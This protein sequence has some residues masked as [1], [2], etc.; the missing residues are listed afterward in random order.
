MIVARRAVCKRV[1]R[2]TIA[3]STTRW[4]PERHVDQVA[5]TTVASTIDGQVTK[6]GFE[7]TLP[8]RA[9]GWTRRANAVAIPPTRAHPAAS[10]RFI[11]PSKASG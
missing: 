1:Y 2:A 11:D 6:S 8:R 7:S 3:A 4:E 5:L 9:A 10:R